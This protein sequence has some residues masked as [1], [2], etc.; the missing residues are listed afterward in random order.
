MTDVRTEARRQ[1]KQE[2][3]VEIEARIATAAAQ[4][5][6]D[7][8]VARA[9]AAAAKVRV[10][11]LAASEETD[12]DILQT[13]GGIMVSVR[14]TVDGLRKLFVLYAARRKQATD[15][16]QEIP[17]DWSPFQI[18]V[19]YGYLVGAEL[20]K[21]AGYTNELGT[22]KWSLHGHYPA[23]DDWVKRERKILGMKDTSN[24]SSEN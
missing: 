22:L 12:Q 18:I 5:E 15:L 21:V 24:D 13:T 8:V 20:S 16:K 3:L 7:V 1:V 14:T 2:D 10:A 19:R 4:M 6:A 11:L 17:A 23:G 9:R